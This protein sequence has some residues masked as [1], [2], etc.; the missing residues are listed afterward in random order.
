MVEPRL[1]V[2]PGCYPRVYLCMAGP[3]RTPRHR[4]PMR[5]P[6][7]PTNPSFKSFR[8]GHNVDVPLSEFLNLTLFF[9]DKG[10]EKSSEVRRGPA[11]EEISSG[12]QHSQCSIGS[13][14]YEK[15][16]LRSEARPVPLSHLN[17][18]RHNQTDPLPGFS[19]LLHSMRSAPRG[20]SAEK[21]RQACCAPRGSDIMRVA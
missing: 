5:F 11:T 17:D 10:L 7:F 21:F 4:C 19:M 12:A 9:A 15:S 14:S 2:G 6:S 3:G 16:D 1:K 13:A 8:C 20:P 18:V